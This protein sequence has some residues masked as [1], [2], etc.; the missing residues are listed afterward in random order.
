MHFL[1]RLD[2]S[3]STSSSSTSTSDP[4]P[5][6]YLFGWPLERVRTR[7]SSIS[8]LSA[9][10]PSD[11]LSCPASPSSPPLPSSSPYTLGNPLSRVRTRSESVDSLIIPP[12]V[13]QDSFVRLTPSHLTVYHVLLRHAVVF[14]LH[15]VHSCRPLLTESQR[16]R[17]AAD[18]KLRRKRRSTS[19]VH[20]STGGIGLDGVVWAKDLARVKEQ[21]AE[22]GLLVVV[23]VE[24]WFGRVG[25]SVA[26]EEKWWEAWERVGGKSRV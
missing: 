24:G 9:C 4:L 22:K 25:F 12:P 23:E 18:E 26:D 17:L 1:P 16:I 7:T 6:P 8:S 21:K 10:P 14:P 3:S 13:Y 2:T 11:F 5:S 15:R 19:L 20:V